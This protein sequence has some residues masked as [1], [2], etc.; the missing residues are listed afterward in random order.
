MTET[1]KD[2]SHLQEVIAANVR[3]RRLRMGLSQ[4][5]FADLCGYHRTYIG[6]IER[7]ERNITVS[8]LEALAKSLGVDPTDLLREDG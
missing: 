5:E 8:T 2:I 7:S 6:S 4:E 3:K 1:A